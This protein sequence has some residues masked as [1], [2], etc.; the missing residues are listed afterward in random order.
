MKII[1]LL[2][3]CV[4]LFLSVGYMVEVIE[5]SRA[6][7]S[8]PASV[9]VFAYGGLAFL[10]VWFLF[11]KRFMYTFSVFEHELTHILI[12]KIFFLKTLHFDV[13]PRKHIE[14][15][16]VVGVEGRGALTN[17]ISVFFSLAPYYVPTLTLLVFILYPFFGAKTAPLFLFAIGF[18]AMYHFFTTFREFGFH[19]ADIQKHGEYF[20]TAFV[21]LGNIIFLGIV[22]GVVLSGNFQDVPGFLL[23]GILNVFG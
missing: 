2:F 7:S 13:S 18:T 8:F 10:V 19:Q 9:K 21:L 3:I 6:V 4:L 11:K 22:L 17:F 1:K 12:A 20:S 16:V 14:G 23:G 5:L 15:Q